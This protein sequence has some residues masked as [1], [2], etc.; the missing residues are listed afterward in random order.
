MA[1]IKIKS[2]KDDRGRIQDVFVDT[3]DLDD[4]D[5]HY[6]RK[7][8]KLLKKTSG[9]DNLCSQYNKYQ[10]TCQRILTGRLNAYEIEHNAEYEWLKD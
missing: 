2:Q 3:D 9:S 8:E 4:A 6:Y 7:C 10:L 5:Y 1:L